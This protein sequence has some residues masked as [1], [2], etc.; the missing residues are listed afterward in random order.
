MT[1]KGLD[2]VISMALE[3]L[4]KF[5]LGSDIKREDED[6]LNRLLSVIPSMTRNYGFTEEEILLMSI[7]LMEEKKPE[8][9]KE[10]ILKIRGRI[11]LLQN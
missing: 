11:R 2:A 6:L 7:L 10:E 8:R 5:E 9:I 4:E 3:I 1:S